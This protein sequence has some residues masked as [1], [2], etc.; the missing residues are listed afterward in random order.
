[1]TY[2][3]AV[4]VILYKHLLVCELRNN[5][6]RRTCFP[7]NPME[8]K[9]LAAVLLRQLVYPSII[10]VLSS[11][12][13]HHRHFPPFYIFFVVDFFVLFVCVVAA[14]DAITRSNWRRQAS[15]LFV[16]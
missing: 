8:G 4:C 14:F 1:M 11:I 6:I 16:L 7:L 10:F 12:I 15:S 13:K 9:V 5:N 2:R 3:V